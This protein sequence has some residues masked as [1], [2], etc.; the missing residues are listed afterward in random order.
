MKGA[1]EAVEI[2]SAVLGRRAS[3]KGAVSQAI[4]LA[5][6]QMADGQRMNYQLSKTSSD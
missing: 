5:L 2:T 3:L 4:S 6:H 1:A